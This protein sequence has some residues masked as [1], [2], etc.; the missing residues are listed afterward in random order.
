MSSEGA[1]E[2]IPDRACRC[3]PERARCRLSVARTTLVDG[4]GAGA[5]APNP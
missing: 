3:A 1:G 4:A 2:G 5:G